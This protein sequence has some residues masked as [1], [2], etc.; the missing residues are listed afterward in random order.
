MPHSDIPADMKVAWPG[1]N[2]PLGVTIGPDG[3]NIAV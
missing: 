3:A 1:R 2:E